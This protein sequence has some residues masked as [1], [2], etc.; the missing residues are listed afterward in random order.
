MLDERAEALDD[1]L[2][3]RDVFGKSHPPLGPLVE[4][5]QAGQFIQREGALQLRPGLR[6]GTEFRFRRAHSHGTD[7]DSK[8]VLSFSGIR[9]RGGQILSTDRKSIE[10]RLRPR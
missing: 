7:Y 4:F 2:S 10:V 1:L 9:L 5:F 8:P 6:Y 3:G